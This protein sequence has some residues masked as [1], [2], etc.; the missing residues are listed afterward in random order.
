MQP[1][2]QCESLHNRA[3]EQ[4]MLQEVLFSQR[5]YSHFPYWV[6]SSY[7]LWL[8]GF[9][10]SI[11]QQRESAYI[12][13]KGENFKSGAELFVAWG[14]QTASQAYGKV[15]IWVDYELFMCSIIF[16]SF[17]FV[18][19]CSLSNEWRGYLNG[20]WLIE[21]CWRRQGGSRPCWTGR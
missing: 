8:L 10:W 12:D 20:N 21:F 1:W 19:A 2:R 6:I 11:I 13:I 3:A 15:I 9:G 17:A 14:Q 18:F 16:W 5:P 7:Y 4:A